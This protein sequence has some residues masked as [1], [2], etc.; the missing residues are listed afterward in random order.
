M[1]AGWK[2]VKHDMTGSV[3]KATYHTVR[4]MEGVSSSE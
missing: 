4:C 3:D 1:I 2:E